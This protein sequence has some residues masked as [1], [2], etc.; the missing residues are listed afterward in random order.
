MSTDVKL[1]EQQLTFFNTFGYLGFP[2]LLADRFAEIESAFEGVWG[3]RGGGHNGKPHDGTAR[4]CI[5]PFIDQSEVLSSLL[6]DPRIHGIAT[7]LLGEDFNYMGSDGNYYVGDTRWHS[8]GWHP[9]TLHIKIAFYL[10][11]LTRDTG[12]LRVIPGS[13]RLGDS[14]AD[15]LQK[16]IRQST[17]LWGKE[18]QDVPAIALETTPGDILVFNHNT[19]HSAFGGSKARRMFTINLCQRYPEARI[20]ELRDY[21]SGGA[22]FWIDRAYGEKMIRTAGPIRQRHLEQVMANDGHLAE[23]SRKARETMAEPSRG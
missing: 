20:Q 11:P 23:L 22:R 13:H 10:D 21:I 19:K 9:Q 7:S 17:E 12:A 5:V 14:Y 2:G 1:T 6:D 16:Q 3:D 8:D 18:G 4:S 15:G